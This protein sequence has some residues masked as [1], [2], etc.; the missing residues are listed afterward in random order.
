MIFDFLKPKPKPDDGIPIQTIVDRLRSLG[1]Y[2][3]EKQR[4]IFGWT[5]VLYGWAISVDQ[6]NNQR[7]I[8]L[9]GL[10]WDPSVPIPWGTDNPYSKAYAACRDRM[11]IL[12]S[13][14]AGQ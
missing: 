4:P 2:S 9:N 5:P 6:R 13:K 8:Y 14:L 7:V 10:A 1:L 3:D 11:R 12:F